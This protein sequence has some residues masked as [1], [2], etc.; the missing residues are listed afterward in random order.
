MFTVRWTH[1][2]G[3][4]LKRLSLVLSGIVGGFA[5]FLVSAVVIAAIYP[6]PAVFSEGPNAEEYS[7]AARWIAAAGAWAGLIIF[8]CVAHAV[9]KM[10]S[11]T[12]NPQRDD[13]Q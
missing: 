11:T 4:T 9:N 6:D 1:T 2:G 13:D 12:D 10:I 5:G 7:S 3:R 8:A